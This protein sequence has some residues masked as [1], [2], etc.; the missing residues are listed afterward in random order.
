[1]TLGG[2]RSILLSYKDMGL[3]Q[4][5]IFSIADNRPKIKRFLRNGCILECRSTIDIGQQEKKKE[6]RVEG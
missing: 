6:K 1:M 2:E 4:A 3:L 5:L